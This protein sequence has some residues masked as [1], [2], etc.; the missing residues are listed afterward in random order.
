MRG[1]E[2]HGAVSRLTPRYSRLQ[3]VTG[4]RARHTER[5]ET[6]MAHIEGEMVINRP[7]EAVFDFVADE[8]NEPRFNPRLTR[9]EKISAG[10]IG[11]GT[12]GSWA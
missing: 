7:V 8:S 6:G 10:P 11:L 1:G 9:V 2:F 5:S 12:A 4:Q 3:P